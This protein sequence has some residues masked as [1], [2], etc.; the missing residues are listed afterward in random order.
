MIK[1][2]MD[3]GKRSGRDCTCGV[4]SA[5]SPK[6]KM[7]MRREAPK[8]IGTE[9]HFRG[10]TVLLRY[11]LEGLRYEI[12]DSVV[13]PRVHFALGKDGALASPRLN[14]TW[15]RAK[16]LI[17]NLREP[18]RPSNFFWRRCLD[19]GERSCPNMACADA[20]AFIKD[21]YELLLETR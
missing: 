6:K 16:V 5:R 15:K 20:S 19:G 3:L 9:P 10:V 13:T 17:C 8:K 12:S 4:R 7:G 21:R 14:L 2:D 1:G 18:Q 11:E